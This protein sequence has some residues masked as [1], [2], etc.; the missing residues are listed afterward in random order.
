MHFLEAAHRILREA[1]EPLHYREITR[2]ASEQGLIQ[3]SGRTPAATMN[4]QLTV[5]IN[6]ATQ[7]GS[8]SP[9]Y[10]AARGMISLVE[11]QT[12][13][14]AAPTP[15]APVSPEQEQP[16]YLSYKAAAIRVLQGAV[17]PLHYREIARRAIEQGLINPQG[18]TPDATMGAQIYT[19]LQRQGGESAFRRE[20]RGIFGLA[21]WQRGTRG[22]LREVARLRREVKGRLL[23][24]LLD[25]EPSEFEQ[26]AGRLLGAMGYENIEVTQRSGDGGVDVLAEIEVG[27]L[28]LRTAVQVKRFRANVQRPV[29]SQLRGDMV[30]WGVDQGMIITTAGFSEGAKEAARVR[31]APTISLIDGERLTDLLIEHSIGVRKEPLE[32]V[33]FAP[34]QLRGEEE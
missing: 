9:F 16:E 10:R 17:Q 25:M 20:G 29:V 5:S 34:E 21:E 19:D 18:L 30:L 32:I 8:P 27:V 22:I 6:R 3:T 28:R 11:W 24:W 31:N 2:R 23:D 7:G 15:R 26:L 13:E 33:A 12:P 4:A 1:G 14:P